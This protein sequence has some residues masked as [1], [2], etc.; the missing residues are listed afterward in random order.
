MKRVF[1]H[2]SNHE[3]VK[4]GM[5]RAGLDDQKV[6]HS[7][8]VLMDPLMFYEHA[9]AMVKAWPKS[10]EHHLTN[11]E[12]NRRAWIGHATCLF[13]HG[14]NMDETISAW[15]CIGSEAQLAAN[16]MALAVIKEF[17]DSAKG[18]ECQKYLFS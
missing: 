12:V 9:K 18:V 13:N 2:I 3:D 6:K 4:A 11:N 10:S 16:N 17:E 7:I 1:H 8:D 15:Q 14:A 5:F